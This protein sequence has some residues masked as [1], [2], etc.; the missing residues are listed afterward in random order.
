LVE[1]GASDFAGLVAI[2][3]RLAI[4]QSLREFMQITTQAARALLR[5]DGITFVLRE[6]DLCLLRGGRRHLAFM[7]GASLPA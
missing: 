2:L 3:R 7:D 1:P 5:A 4:S 6:G